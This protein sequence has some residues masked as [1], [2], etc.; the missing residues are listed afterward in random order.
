MEFRKEFFR[1]PRVFGDVALLI[2]SISAAWTR[3]VLFQGVIF[4]SIQEVFS[5][6]NL[7]SIE[8]LHADLSYLRGGYRR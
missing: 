7:H 6:D 3:T 1:D 4:G 5:S 2:K 8:E